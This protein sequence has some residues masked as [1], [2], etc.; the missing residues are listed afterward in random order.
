MEE[1]LTLALI[2]VIGWIFTKK[3]K[4]YVMR[5]PYDLRDPAYNKETFAPYIREAEIANGIPANLLF[6]LIDKESAFRS[7]II[8][9]KVLSSAGAVGIAQI[10]PKWHPNVNPLN[11]LEAIEYAAYYLRENYDALRSWD[12]AVAAYNAGP[13]AI[14]NVVAKYGSQWLAYAPRE[15]QDYVQKIIG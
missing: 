11:P 12:K 4:D 15:T 14:K 10:V 7:D 1:L 6:R 3:N 5:D 9:G 13:T 2:G 8:S